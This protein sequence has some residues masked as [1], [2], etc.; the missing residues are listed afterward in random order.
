MRLIEITTRQDSTQTNDTSS[1]AM[2]SDV[3]LIWLFEFDSA[4]ICT[5]KCIK[6]PELRSPTL[7]PAPQHETRMHSYFQGP[8]LLQAFSKSCIKHTTRN[9]Q[10]DHDYHETLREP[11][12]WIPNEDNCYYYPIDPWTVIDAEVDNERE[13]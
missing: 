1:I 13:F 12:L 10:K 8:Y 7:L 2:S 3:P 6:G 9:P 11:L 5:N 4:R